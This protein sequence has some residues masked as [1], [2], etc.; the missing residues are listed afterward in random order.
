MQ[1]ARRGEEGRPGQRRR[2]GG[3]RRQARRDAH[4]RPGQGVC[5]GLGARGGDRRARVLLPAAPSLTEAHRRE[6]QR[7]D[8]GALSQGQVPRRRHRWGG[9]A[10]VR[11]AEPQAAKV[12]GMEMP[13]R[14]VL[15]GVV[16]LDLRIRLSITLIVPTIIRSLASAWR[17]R[18]Y[19]M[20]LTPSRR[21]GSLLF[22]CAMKEDGF[23]SGL[24]RGTSS[25][26]IFGKTE[27]RRIFPVLIRLMACVGGLR[28]FLRTSSMQ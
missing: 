26:S 2:Q 9:A 8:Q 24:K 17:M 23:R 12:P 28:G 15:R 16:A 18:S 5:E 10:G 20:R 22:W 7:P 11:Y 3:A 25:I 4:A 27:R 21:A 13:A 14:G 1:R 6:L 19:A